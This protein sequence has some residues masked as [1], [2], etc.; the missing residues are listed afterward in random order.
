MK[1]RRQSRHI[2]NAEQ[3]EVYS[4]EGWVDEARFGRI[5]GSKVGLVEWQNQVDSSILSMRK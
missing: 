4:V 1:E 5:G 2:D 3:T